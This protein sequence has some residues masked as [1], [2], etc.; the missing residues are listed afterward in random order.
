MRCLQQGSD[1]GSTR[2]SPQ[3]A[4][5]GNSAGAVAPEPELAAQDA[6]E[7]VPPSGKSRVWIVRVLSMIAVV[8]AWEILGHQVDPL[9][10]PSPSA[11]AVAAVQMIVSGELL[12]GLA[13]SLQT[14]I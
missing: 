12:V 11:I 6:E 10:L 9:F 8:G 5:S 7:L 4:A 1:R 13:S 3:T 2:M 14:L